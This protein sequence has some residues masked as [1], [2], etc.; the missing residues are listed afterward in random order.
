MSRIDS[1]KNAEVRSEVLDPLAE[2]AERRGV[3]ILA[4]THFNKGSGNALNRVSGSV[5]FPA[6]ARVVWGF[7]KDPADPGPNGRRLML[8][9]KSNVGPEVP[10]LAYRIVGTD[11]GRATISWV[12]GE[13]NQTLND[14]LQQEQEEQ[15]GDKVRRACELIRSM[16]ANGAAPSDDINARARELGIG[17]YSVREA[18]KLLGCR[19]R[20]AGGFADKGAWM[21]SLPSG[22]NDAA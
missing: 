13:V 5:A 20:R 14:V 10:G 6:A 7:S 18:K 1:H 11:N 12:A 15:K 16:C 8:F 17:D 9:G 2:L 21:V 4:V 3:T 22:S 19:S